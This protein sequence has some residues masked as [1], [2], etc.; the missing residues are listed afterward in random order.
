[1]SSMLMLQELYQYSAHANE[2]LFGKMFGSNLMENQEV[3]YL[4]HRL[5]NHSYIVCD[6]FRSHLANSSHFYIEDNPVNLPSFNDLYN[7]V[8]ALDEWYVNYIASVTPADL[9]EYIGF[10][11]TDGNH[12]CMTRWEI[13]LHVATH[14]IYH[15]G[16]VGRIMLQ[17]DITPPWDTLAV[18]LHQTQ[19]LRRVVY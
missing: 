5:L 11:F 6:I 16:E 13:L 12:G 4:A 19:P 8:R 14:G 7:D 2:E 15:R 10:T 17:H 18:Y 9:D 3:F 1:M